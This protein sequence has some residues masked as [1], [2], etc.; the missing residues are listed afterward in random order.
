MISQALVQFKQ[1]NPQAI[2]IMITHYCKILD[3]IIP[4][5]I[6][7]LKDGTIVHSGDSLL[8]QIIQ[9]RGYDSF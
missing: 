9:E 5:Y 8:A 3:Y 6:H 2:I 7:I 4:D 1:E